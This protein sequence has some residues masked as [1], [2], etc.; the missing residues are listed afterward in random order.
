MPV[1]NN[2]TVAKPGSRLREFGLVLPKAPTPLGAYGVKSLPIG[3]PVMVEVI[4][5]IK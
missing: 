1:D 2:S 5:E 4:F 3:T